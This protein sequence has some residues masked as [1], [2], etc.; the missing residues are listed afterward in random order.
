MIGTI[1]KHS[2][3]LWMIIITATIISFV[4]WGA[5]SAKV[6]GSGGGNL[7][8]VY[9]KKVTQD[10]YFQAKKDFFLSYWFH[11]GKWPDEGTF[12]PTELD[13]QIYLN[14]MLDQKAQQGL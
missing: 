12:T 14:L 10:E 4:F 8:A 1:R 7:G 2:G 5:S 6:G 3:W 11:S 13:Q 9:G